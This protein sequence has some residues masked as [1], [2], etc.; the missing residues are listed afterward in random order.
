M[1]RRHVYILTAIILL[2]IIVV[3]TLNLV[4]QN[5]TIKDVYR[6]SYDR[7]YDQLKTIDQTPILD[8]ENL[9]I[10]NI[11]DIK[12][13]VTK[14]IENASIIAAISDNS[15]LYFFS[16]NINS[17]IYEIENSYNTNKLFNQLDYEKYIKVREYINKVKVIMENVNF[18]LRQSNDKN[19]KEL[20]MSVF[21]LNT[22]LR[23]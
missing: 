13:N 11:Q 12:I 22:K 17:L 8:K 2:G 16:T 19:F 20:Q 5:S 21:E 1:K 15:E 3:L 23:E 10:K 4:K 14:T 7:Y 18:K 6:I 9:D